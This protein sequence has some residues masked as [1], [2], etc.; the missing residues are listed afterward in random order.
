MA[1]RVF[2]SSSGKMLSWVFKNVMVFVNDIPPHEYGLKAP[3][4]IKVV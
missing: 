2:T 4:L 3:C 1:K